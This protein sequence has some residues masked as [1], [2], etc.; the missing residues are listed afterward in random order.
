MFGIIVLISNICNY[1]MKWKEFHVYDNKSSKYIPNISGVYI[2]NYEKSPIKIGYSKDLKIRYNEYLN[3]SEY[4]DKKFNFFCFLLDDTE[5]SIE[6]EK[7]ILVLL[8]KLRAK[9]KTNEE[10]LLESF[11]NLNI[12]KLIWIVIF[13]ITNFN[14]FRKLN[15]FTKAIKEDTSI[16]ALETLID[17]NNDLLY[18]MYIM[19]INKN[20]IHDYILVKENTKKR[21]RIREVNK[22]KDISFNVEDKDNND[23][24]H[25]QFDI[26]NLILMLENSTIEWKNFKDI[27]KSNF[28]LK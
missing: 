22:N 13:I 19:Y 10:I 2:I 24:N 25:D 15:L 18:K 14:N 21:R 7:I 6:I 28:Y 1:N 16:N 12:D 11:P 9:K 26:D 23:I 3:N 5:K 17:Y 20:S 8:Y 4:I 27:E